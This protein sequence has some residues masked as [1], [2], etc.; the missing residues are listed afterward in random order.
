MIALV[1]SVSFCVVATGLCLSITASAWADNL[2]ALTDQQLDRVT[3]GGAAVAAITDAQ[4]AG[5]LT[6][7]S[8]TANSLVVPGPSP[9][10]G[11]PGLAPTGGAAD[12]TALAVG[13]NL[14]L[15]GEPPAS[16]NTAVATGGV[17]NGNQVVNSTFNQTVNGAGG[18][19]FQAGWTFVYGAWIGL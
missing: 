12:G 14:G 11:Q 1:K 16:S 3:A 15:G 8:T 10:P 5:V 19:R 6:L 13:T 18:V 4:A 7:T 2:V 17:A 9:Y